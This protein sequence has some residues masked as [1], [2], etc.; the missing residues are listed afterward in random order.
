MFRNAISL[1]IL[2]LLVSTSALADGNKVETVG[3]FKDTAA[4]DSVRAALEPAGFKISLPDGAE[5]CQ[6]WLRKDLPDYPVTDAQGAILT[7]LG[8]SSLIGVIEFPKNTT[9]YRG[10]VIKA[11]EYTLRYADDPAD[12]NH[13]GVAPNRDFLLMVPISVDKDAAAKIKFEDLVKLSAQSAGTNHPAGLSLLSAEGQK[14][15]PAAISDDSGHVILAA[16]LKTSSG[17]QLPFELIV[18]GVADQ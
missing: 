5:V 4:S 13:L 15:F 11:G 14:T 10:Q 6:I 2:L 12:G 8:N 1:V 18:K 7:Q 16:K 9:D 17:A 3:A